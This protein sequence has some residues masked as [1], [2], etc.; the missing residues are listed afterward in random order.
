MFLFFWKSH[1]WPSLSFFKRKG[2]FFQ[3]FE[4]FASWNGVRAFQVLK[5]M[6][7][8][9]FQVKIRRGIDSNWSQDAYWC[10]SGRFCSSKSQERQKRNFQNTQGKWSASRDL[11]W[12]DNES[13]FW[14]SVKS[15]HQALV[16][17][18][19]KQQQKC[20]IIHQ[21]DQWRRVFD[22]CFYFVTRIESLFGAFWS[23]EWFLAHSEL[24]YIYKTHM[25]MKRA[26]MLEPMAYITSMSSVRLRRE[27]FFRIWP[28]NLSRILNHVVTFIAYTS[29][30]EHSCTKWSLIKP[31]A[32]VVAQKVFWSNVTSLT[33]SNF[34]CDEGVSFSSSE[35]C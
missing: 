2:E 25:I 14:G 22:S 21:S 26:D 3:D 34:L 18:L 12:K 11:L 15:Y 6:S 28:R 5:I 27:N 30:R 9:H 33:A 10:P 35:L 17:R 20:H 4:I 8:D 7:K 23:S 1:F 19:W 13:I 29:T 16:S 32:C 24:Y 31:A